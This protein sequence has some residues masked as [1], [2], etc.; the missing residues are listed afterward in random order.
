MQEADYTTSLHEKI[1]RRCLY[2]L[3]SGFSLFA[4]TIAPSF[5][6]LELCLAATF[7]GTGIPNTAGAIKNVSFAAATAIRSPSD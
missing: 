2:L 1:S 5:D 3:T 4:T 7:V 6:T